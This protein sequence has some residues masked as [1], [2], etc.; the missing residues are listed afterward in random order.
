MPR[1]TVFTCLKQSEMFKPDNLFCNICNIVVNIIKSISEHQKIKS[2][3]KNRR[4]PMQDFKDPL[5]SFN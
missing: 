5:S 4:I 2:K 1:K 3:A